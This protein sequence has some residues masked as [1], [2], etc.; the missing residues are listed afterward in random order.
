MALVRKTQPA[1]LDFALDALQEHLWNSLDLDNW[2]SY[3]RAYKNP[4]SREGGTG[5]VAE[6]YQSNGEYVTDAY[7]DDK[8]STVSFF[9]LA[10]ELIDHPDG[11]LNRARCA[12]IVQLKLDKSYTTIHRADEELRNDVV[13]AFKQFRQVMNLQTITGIP[14]VYRGFDFEALRYDD[15][16][17]IHVLR[18]EFDLRYNDTCCS[19]C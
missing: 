17:N 11:E 9:I 15:M 19:N 3:H 5:F 2:Q 1:G 7:F 4:K 10:D 6:I 8:F 13:G 12:W 14:N 16:S 18:V